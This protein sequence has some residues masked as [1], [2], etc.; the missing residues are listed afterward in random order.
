MMA[1]P[2]F[3]TVVMKSPSSHA[4]SVMTDVVGWPPIVELAKS[5]NCVAEW[6]PQIAICLT[7]ATD[8]PAFLASWV[9]ARFWSRRVIAN[10]RSAGT[11]GALLRAIRQ[12][13]LQGLPTTRTRTSLAAFL[14][15]ASPWGLKMPPLTLS[16][17]PRSMPALRGIEPTSSA[18]EVL[19]NAVSRFEVASMPASSG[20]AQSS[21]SMTTPSSAFI[22]GSISSKRSTTGWSAPRSWPLAMR[23]RSW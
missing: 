18:H 5:G 15:I 1:A 14:A 10:Q 11:S 16:R 4:W 20:N 19:V 8:T 6:L 21:S 9:C 22:A 13:V 17:S 7:S 23:K 3:C 2:R 12:L